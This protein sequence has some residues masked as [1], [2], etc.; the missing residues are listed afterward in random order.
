MCGMAK[1][2]LS[3]ENITP[4]IKYKTVSFSMPHIIENIQR[5]D[6]DKRMKKYYIKIKLNKSY[7]KFAILR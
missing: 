3:T 5:E 1:L 7:I 2:S 6:I 4:A